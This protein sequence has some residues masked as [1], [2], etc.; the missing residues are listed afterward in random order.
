M[1]NRGRD[2]LRMSE[3]PGSRIVT[4]GRT[5]SSTFTG[6]SSEHAAAVA[7]TA[8]AAASQRGRLMLRPS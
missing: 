5:T 6:S 3:S 2:V 1:W 4:S 7:A 8:H